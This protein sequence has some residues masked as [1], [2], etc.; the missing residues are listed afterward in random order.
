MHW[1]IL[2]DSLTQAKLA[3]SKYLNEKYLHWDFRYPIIEKEF[4]MVDADVIGISSMD[5]EIKSG[6]SIKDLLLQLGYDY[7]C[8][9]LP[10]CKKDGVSYPVSLFYKRDKFKLI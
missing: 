7:Y 6:K 5:L 4:R 8:E 1:D 9:L 10:S 3:N 2:P